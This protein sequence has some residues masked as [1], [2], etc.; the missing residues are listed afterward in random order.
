MS[1]DHARPDVGP[2]FSASLNCSTKFQPEVSKRFYSSKAKSSNVR[3]FLVAKSTVL[4]R[5][6]ERLPCSSKLPIKTG[7]FDRATLSSAKLNSLSAFLG[8]AG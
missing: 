2:K 5:S 7:I 3:D 4:L 6:V 1:P 8:L